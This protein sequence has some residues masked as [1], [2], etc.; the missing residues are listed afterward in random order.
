MEVVLKK[1]KINNN[2]INQSELISPVDASK[3]KMLGWCNHSKKGKLLIFYD[4]D[5]HAIKIADYVTEGYQLIYGGYDGNYYLGGKYYI[6]CYYSSR[7]ANKF[8][9]EDDRSQFL[10]CRAELNELAATLG[11]IYI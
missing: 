8:E 9:T 2:I 1:T 7:R 10:R 5:N 11:Q 6:I 3:L 4:T